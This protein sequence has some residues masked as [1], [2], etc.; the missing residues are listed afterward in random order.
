MAKLVIDKKFEG[1]ELSILKP[2]MPKVI[3]LS[4]D[5]DQALLKQLQELGFEGIKSVKDGSDNKE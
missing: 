1:T 2:G 4:N 5:L 3:V